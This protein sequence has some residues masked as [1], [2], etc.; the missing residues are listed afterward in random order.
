MVSLL[1]RLQFK[2]NPVRIVMAISEEATWMDYEPDYLF[3]KSPRKI[4][5]YIEGGHLQL[6]SIRFH[7]EL[8][9][10]EVSIDP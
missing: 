2:L 5:S 8:D 6:L 7:D 1:D 4:V 10:I 9:E 3:Y